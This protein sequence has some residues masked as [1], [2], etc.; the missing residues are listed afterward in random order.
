M[1]PAPPARSL[2]ATLVVFGLAACDSEGLPEPYNPYDPAFGG[3]RT[4]T[5]PDGLALAGSTPTSVTLSWTDR[6]SFESGVRV[7]SAVE[8]P[9]EPLRFEPVATL[10]PGATAYTDTG[11]TDTAPRRYRVVAL[12]DGGNA[13]AP[14][15]PVGVRYPADTLALN[16]PYGFDVSGAQFSPDGERLYLFSSPGTGVVD[17]R[18]GA[19]LPGIPNVGSFIGFLD[20]GRTAFAEPSSTP[21][22]LGLRVFGGSGGSVVSTY[23]FSQGGCDGFSGLRTSASGPRVAAFCRG[24]LYVWDGPAP[25]PSRTINVGPVNIA[26]QLALSPDG[27]VAYVKAYGSSEQAVR[28]YGADTGAL[29]WTYSFSF[30]HPTVRYSPDGSTL[31]AVASGRLRFVDARTGALRSSDEF[32]GVSEVLD[33]SGDRAVGSYS[34]Y[35]NGQGTTSLR[36]VRAEGGSLVRTVTPTRASTVRLIPDGLVVFEGAT[37]SSAPRAIR[38]D[39]GASW[40]SVPVP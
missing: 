11:L 6:S 36:V 23:G 21:Y 27:S 3:A 18:T 19:T 22:A 13:S 38:W 31:A 26:T 37:A 29:I 8:R 35:V 28:A 4:A 32:Y 2:L 7:E 14:S 40:E 5:A 25:T 33:V 39:L 20:G 16:G 17:V 1:M 30:G 34:T 12:V 24:L 10:P 15:E 9:G